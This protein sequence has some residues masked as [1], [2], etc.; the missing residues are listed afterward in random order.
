MN[1]YRDNNNS[2]GGY[3]EL[4]TSLISEYHSNAFAINTARNALEYILLAKKI[5]KIYLPYFTCDVLLEPLKKL[6][7]PFEFYTIDSNFEPFFDFSKLKENDFL[8][9]TNYFGLKD[10]YINEL[11]NKCN[12]LIIDNAQAFFSKPIE[13]VSTIYSARKFFGVSDGAYLYCN[14]QL[15]ENFDTDCSV[16]RMSHLLIRK[17]ISAEV[18][19]SNFIINDKSLENQP[20]K[21]M[22]KL[23]KSILQSIDYEKI[24]KVRIDNFNMLHRALGSKNKLI[25]SFLKSNVPL[26]Y[27]FWSDDKGLRKSLFENKIYTATYWP[28]VKDWCEINSLEYTLTDEIIN[29]PIDQRYSEIE[30]E[31]II[32]TILNV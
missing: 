11:V 6:Q 24:A 19:Y 7:L 25:L 12:N 28:N 26:V 20:I 8:L 4:E 27:P 15:N 2:I 3:F 30:M 1:Y 31:L 10:A 9:Y 23:T 18:G 13:G 21:L 32:N 17:D 16:E 5:Q 14:E 22:S 29:L